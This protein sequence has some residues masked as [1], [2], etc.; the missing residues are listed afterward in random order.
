MA[1][2]R[3]LDPEGRADTGPVTVFPIP[4]PS[5][6]PGKA[7]RAG[8]AGTR[9]AAPVLARAHEMA[10]CPPT[11]GGQAAILGQDAPVVNDQLV[12]TSGLVAASRINVAPPNARTV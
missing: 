3:D 7:F 4:S 8:T 2:G 11:V 5:R 6:L 9:M 10:A 12:E 1:T